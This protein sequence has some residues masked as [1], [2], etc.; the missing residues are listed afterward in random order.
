MA[1]VLK[2]PILSKEQIA[3]IDNLEDW[4]NKYQSPLQHLEHKLHDWVTYLI[5]PVFA[6]ANAGVVL[7]SDIAF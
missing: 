2:K 3:A 7:N 5:I 6:L 1:S 4:T